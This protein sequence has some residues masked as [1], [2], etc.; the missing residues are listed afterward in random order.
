VEKGTGQGCAQRALAVGAARLRHE[1]DV[2]L[3]QVTAEARGS[4]VEVGN[5]TPGGELV[6]EV[7]DQV[8]LGEPFDQTYLPDSDSELTCEAT[9]Q[10]GP[11]RPLCDHEPDELAIGDERR[12]TSSS[13]PGSMR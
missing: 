4:S 8:S 7:G 2:R 10:L 6:Q 9:R 1:R 12:R 13:P 3:A 11:S 5:R